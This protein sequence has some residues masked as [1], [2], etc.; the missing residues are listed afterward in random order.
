MMMDV[1]GDVVECEMSVSG[2]I[3][4]VMMVVRRAA[5]VAIGFLE[6]KY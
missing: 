3:D 2:G 4:V 6:A 5:S 1:M